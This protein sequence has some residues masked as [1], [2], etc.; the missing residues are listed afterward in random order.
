MSKID[1]R[2]D[3]KWDENDKAFK[4]DHL[5]HKLPMLCPYAMPGTCSPTCAAFQT[6]KGRRF[7][8]EWFSDDVA[9]CFAHGMMYLGHV[10]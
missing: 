6:V 3:I 10:E 4:L 9:A 2:R 7:V 1:H 5:G 8:S